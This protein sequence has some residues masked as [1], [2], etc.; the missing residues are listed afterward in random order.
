MLWT[1]SLCTLAN[2]DLHN[3]VEHDPFTNSPNANIFAYLYLLDYLKLDITV[4]HRD[5]TCRN[6]DWNAVDCICIPSQKHFRI[7]LVFL[8]RRTFTTF[9]W[10]TWQR[11]NVTNRCRKD[12][13]KLKTSLKEYTASNVSVSEE[14]LILKS[15]WMCPTRRLRLRDRR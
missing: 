1:N 8:R 14:A 15:Q 10:L 2:E 5:H 6:N 11:A 12:T 7:V 4:H 3:F 9:S 13:D